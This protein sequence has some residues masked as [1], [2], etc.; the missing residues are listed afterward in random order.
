MNRT[1]SSLVITSVL[2]VFTVST[3]AGTIIKLGFSTDSL[4]D[5]ELIDGALSTADDGIGATNGDQNTEVTFLGSLVS[6]PA[7]EGDNASFTLDGVSLVD[8]PT[9]FGTTILHATEGGTFSLYD[10][11]DSLLLA[12]TL[13]I[14]TLSGPIGGTATGGFLT[15]EFGLSRTD[16]YSTNWIRTVCCV[17]RSRSA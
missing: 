1:L 8:M 2:L 14:G 10:Q 15:T 4:P 17:R 16:R 13:G 3:N 5:I 9:I 6:Q 11:N 7:I 12:G